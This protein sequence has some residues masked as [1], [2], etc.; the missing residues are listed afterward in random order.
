MY[1]PFPA[2]SAQALRSL[3]NAHLKKPSRECLDFSNPTLQSTTVENPCST[4]IHVPV[5]VSSKRTHGP[6]DK[7]V[8]AHAHTMSHGIIINYVNA[9]FLVDEDINTQTKEWI[10]KQK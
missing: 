8:F 10:N 6:R 4:Q 9:A 1:K 5:A 3:I 7:I 2:T